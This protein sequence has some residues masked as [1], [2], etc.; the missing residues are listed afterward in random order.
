V[1]RPP[2][3]H[4]PQLPLEAR[5]GTADNVTGRHTRRTR[6]W[7]LRLHPQRQ[8]RLL[9]RQHPRPQDLLPTWW[10]GMISQLTRQ[11][12][13]LYVLPLLQDERSIGTLVRRRYACARSYR[14]RDHSLR[15]HMRLRSD[16]RHQKSKTR[17]RAWH[18][19]APA[20]WTPFEQMSKTLGEREGAAFRQG[21]QHHRTTG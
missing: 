17:M 6:P 7:L 2:H 3:V 9:L 15:G 14:D 1:S 13:R 19:R 20:P 4:Y 16:A 18:R 8:D 11:I 12:N 5:D 10:H 21:W